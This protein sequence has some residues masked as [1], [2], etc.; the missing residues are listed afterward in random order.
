[1]FPT[2]RIGMMK[3]GRKA[4][5]KSVSRQSRAII[6]VNVTSHGDEVADDA[7]ERVAD[8][9]L[10]GADIVVNAREDL[11]GPVRGEPAQRHAAEVAVEPRAQVEHHAL[12]DDGAQVRLRDTEERRRR[13]EHD[14]QEDEEVELA[15][16]R[17]AEDRVVD[18]RL[19][20]QRRAEP[21]EGAQRDYHEEQPR[22]GH[23]GDGGRI[24]A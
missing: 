21:R 4:T 3:I 6:T 20:Q 11:A 15:V 9:A 13:D 2:R 14:H 7:A 22:S 17:V 12:A 23:A 24:R 5:E 19:D 8:H 18:D 1:M 10:D 16:V